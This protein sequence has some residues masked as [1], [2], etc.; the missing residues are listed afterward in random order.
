[1]PAVQQCHHPEA[2]LQVD[3]YRMIRTSSPEPAQLRVRIHCK[4]CHAT[5]DFRALNGLMQAET[6]G[7]T[8]RA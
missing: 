7:A 2:Q 3:T 5:A 1:M 4:E 8:F 6:A